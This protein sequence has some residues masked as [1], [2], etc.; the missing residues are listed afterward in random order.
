MAIFN[1][2]VDVWALGC[3]LFELV[4]RKK[5]FRDDWDVLECARQNVKRLVPR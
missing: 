5:A 1:D 3:I 2:R 4:S